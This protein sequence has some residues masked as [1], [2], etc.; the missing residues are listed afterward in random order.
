MKRGSMPPPLP[1]R[2]ENPR[3]REDRALQEFFSNADK[4]HRAALDDQYLQEWFDFFRP[5]FLQSVWKT[6]TNVDI[7]NVPMYKCCILFNRMGDFHWNREFRKP[8]I[9]N[10][11]LDEEKYNIADVSL[12][13]EFWWNNYAHL[14]WTAEADTLPTNEK[15]LLED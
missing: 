12:L 2:V 1:G 11:P 5:S 7:Y 6:G 3:I 9:L 4:M 10:K 15:Q 8:A 13:K 14:I